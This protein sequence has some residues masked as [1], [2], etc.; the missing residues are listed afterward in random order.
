MSDTMAGSDAETGGPVEKLRAYFESVI[1]EKNLGDHLNSVFQ[2]REKME[3]A[4]EFFVD[5]TFPLPNHKMHL[6]SIPHGS[7]EE[8]WLS[9]K[10]FDYSPGGK[11]G[12]YPSN[13]QFEVHFM[14]FLTNGYKP[15]MGCVDIRFDH[16]SGDR[17]LK[18]HDVK[19]VD[20][21]T[22]VLLM[23]SIIA[24]CAELE[25]TARDCEHPHMQTVLSS[26]VAVRCT[27]NF[28][29]NESDHYLHSLKLG[30][31]TSEKQS[32]SP[33]NIAADIG[34]AIAME[35]KSS[36]VGPKTPLKDVLKKC[37]ASYNRMV[38]VKKH[39]IDSAKWALIYNLLRAP[40]E[41]FALLH[42]HY[43]RFKHECSGVP[44]EVLSMDFWVPGSTTRQELDR[45]KGK[46]QFK[47]ILTPTKETAMLYFSRAT[48]DFI[49]KV[50]KD[51][52]T[53]TKKSSQLSEDGHLN[54]H[55]VVCC[56]L[57]LRKSMVTT[58]PGELVDQHDA[59]FANGHLDSDISTMMKSGEEFVW[60]RVPFIL[61]ATG[62]TMETY[63][64]DHQDKSRNAL[65]KALEASFLAWREELR[66]DQAQFESEKVLL[67][68]EGAK[69]RAKLVR[70]L[71]DCHNR[72]WECV[73]NFIA[74]NLTQFVG[75]TVEAESTVMPASRAW[76][77]DQAK[78]LGNS[79]EDHGIILFLNCPAIGVMSAARLS[80]ILNYI[81]NVLA[82]FP[83]NSVCFVVHPN[84]A[85]QE[86]RKNAGV[87]KEEEQD[88]DMEPK[89]KVKCDEDEEDSDD[90]PVKSKK[91]EHDDLVRKVRFNLETELALPERNLRVKSLTYV[92]D[93]ASIYG[94]REGVLPGL[95]V[96]SNHP[97]NIYRQTRGYKTGTVMG[98]NMLPRNEMVKP[99]SASPNKLPH[100]GRA[101]TDIQ[102]Q[103]QVA[104]G[105]DFVART[106][107][108][109]SVPSVQANIIMD[110]HGY[111]GCAAMS[112]VED[113]AAGKTSVCGT[114]CLDNSGADMMQRVGNRIYDNS[115]SGKLTIKGFPEF[116]PVIAALRSS[117]VQDRNKSYRV[118][119][120]QHDCLM[121]LEVY[122]KKWLQTES[123][124]QR[125]ETIIHEHNATYNATDTYWIPERTESD[126]VKTEPPAKR[127]K[128][129]NLTEQEVS[130]MANV[131]K[132]AI[133]NAC[134]L[135]LAG[136]A[137]DNLFISSRSRNQFFEN[138]EM[139]SFGPGEWRDAQEASEVVSDAE[140]RWISFS[141]NKE[142]LMLL[143]RKGLPEHLQKL[144][145]VDSVVFLQSLVCD[146]Q[147]AGEVKL[148]V[149][150]HKQSDG[151]SL[152]WVSSKPLV[153]VLDECQEVATK[154]KG[155]KGKKDGV[156]ISNKNFG[157]WMSITKIKTAMDTLKI[158]WRCR[159]DS[160]N[161]SGIK[162]ITP[163]RPILCL[164]QQIDVNEAT[165][166]LM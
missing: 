21:Q 64:H 79:P 26:F 101:F 165:L 116:D 145:C 41:L 75:R 44:H 54:L 130:K 16:G 45:F 158:G 137:G 88:E 143:E 97:K 93:P 146:L 61:E 6:G 162:V 10:H 81:S 19:F 154:K 138:R 3:Q 121:I 92:F 83:L 77:R 89:G 102:E 66:A 113:I 84:R 14:E 117:N 65:S 129:E 29:E 56:W 149:S 49:R 68:K 99:E 156:Q 28:F 60:D 52:T 110:M 76:L 151:A 32:P 38:T 2:D 50:G 147:D 80:F 142:T 118:S 135:I 105:I 128:L 59:L 22:K 104:G 13:Q 34:A 98:I 95:V 46:A 109:F 120:Q 155:K 9:L 12:Y 133:N 5:G 70:Q 114:L 157:S 106:I 51:A 136:E 7:L 123:T 25:L 11:N 164:G 115:R 69:V 150:H 15:S 94:K 140:G 20:G 30:Y 108:A 71:E 160:S 31:V 107:D 58:F 139:C 126:E 153:F 43:D 100:F 4:I 152:E 166:R 127:I 119:A 125:A 134:D 42:A 87:K 23:L 163:I 78:E 161:T 39:K 24:F 1:A 73:S 63:V 17:S 159:L 55:D 27:Y 96:L 85:Q 82:D 40:T 62:K 144:E 124:R 131:K 91:D 53:K 8:C 47:E 67:E 141:A 57:W 18:L 37:V 72:A 111:D 33:V 132:I 103:K 36:R 90:E 112:V 148:E 86:G 35:R 74:E 48:Q 122:A